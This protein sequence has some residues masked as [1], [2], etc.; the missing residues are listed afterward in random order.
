MSRTR[1]MN[2]EHIYIRLRWCKRIMGF[3]L[4]IWDT[5]I[6]HCT[7]VSSVC[8]NYFCQS[9]SKP[10]NVFSHAVNRTHFKHNFIYC[11]YINCLMILLDFTLVSVSANLLPHLVNSRAKQRTDAQF[12]CFSPFTFT[13]QHDFFLFKR[14]SF[15]SKR[16]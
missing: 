2:T 3:N 13:L 4:L 16:Q 14:L 6:S 10:F 8:M 9:L 5:Y 12:S 15:E 1:P 11:T 7:C